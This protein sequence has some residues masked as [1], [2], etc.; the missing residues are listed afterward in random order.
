MNEKAKEFLYKQGLS[1]YD[2]MDDGMIEHISENMQ[3]YHLEQ[4]TLTDAGWRSEQL[5]EFDVQEINDIV[6]DCKEKKEDLQA[7][8]C[9]IWNKGYMTGVVDGR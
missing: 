8:I 4:L 9:R 5:P 3:K 6:K 1:N 2:Y 7:L